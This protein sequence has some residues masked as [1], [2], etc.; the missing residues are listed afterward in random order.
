D[1]D[2][3]VDDGCGDRRALLFREQLGD[4]L[5]CERRRRQELL[6]LLPLQGRGDTGD[7]LAALQRA[8][9]GSIDA[10]GG[11]LDRL[12]VR[13]P[14]RVHFVQYGALALDLLKELLELELSFEDIFAALDLSARWRLLRRDVGRR[15]AA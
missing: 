11:F 3:G 8:V 15:F 9:I 7:L 13:H 4:G 1:A 6:L 2:A 14:R 12:R 10:L 5:R